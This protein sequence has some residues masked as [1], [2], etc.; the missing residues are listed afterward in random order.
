MSQNPPIGSKLG[1][2]AR[3]DVMVTPDQKA[4]LSTI[5]SKRGEHLSQTLRRYVAEGIERES[6]R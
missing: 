6:E 4:Q 5:A 1:Y 3:I 2:S